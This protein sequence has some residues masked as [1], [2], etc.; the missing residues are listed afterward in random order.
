MKAQRDDY[1]TT[2]NARLDE[3]DKKVDGLNERSRR[4]EGN[5]EIKL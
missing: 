4:D 5:G 3:F 2:M 1:V